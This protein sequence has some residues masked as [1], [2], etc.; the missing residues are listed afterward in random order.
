MIIYNSLLNK[1]KKLSSTDSLPT[2][3]TSLV[4]ECIV[5]VDY[6]N[7]IVRFTV[8]DIESSRIIFDNRY[9]PLKNTIEVL[10]KDLKSIFQKVFS[11]QEED[12]KYLYKSLECEIKAKNYYFSVYYLIPLDTWYER[13][14]VHFK[15]ITM[16]S[17]MVR[18]DLLSSFG[19]TNDYL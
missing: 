6:L 4:Y 5:G 9:P 12:L 16:S 8:R 1:L 2:R 3:S 15:I 11:F 17:R 10:V 14:T 7:K 13:S 18:D 19:H